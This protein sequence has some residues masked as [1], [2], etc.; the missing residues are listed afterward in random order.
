MNISNEELLSKT[1]NTRVLSNTSFNNGLLGYSSFPANNKGNVITFSDTTVGAETVF[2]QRNDFIGYSHIQTMTPVYEG[3][4]LSPGV[5]FYIISAIRKAI[6]GKY[7]Y[8]IKFNRRI[9]KEVLIRLPV[10]S[11]KRLDLEYMKK[12][13][14]EIMNVCLLRIKAEHDFKL[15]EYMR[16]LSFDS[17]EE[18]LLNEA[19]YEV[20][21]EWKSSKS[22]IYKLEDLFD[23]IDRGMRIKSSDRKQGDLPFITAGLINMGLSSYID[24]STCRIFPENSLTIDM[25]GSTFYRGYNFGADDHVTVLTNSKHRFNKECLQ[26]LQVIIEKRLVGKFSYSRNFYPKNAKD[27]TIFLPE[28]ASDVDITLMQNYIKVIGKIVI[29]KIISEFK[30]KEKILLEVITNGEI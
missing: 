21:K 19:D 13:S 9:A 8:G 25:F 27:L 4:E 17:I 20:L 15:R 11:K 26:Y 18:S 23:K 7:N 28:R 2:Y 10:T 3:L 29:G 30:E 5:A 14:K 22:A 6:A 16:I 24:K 1:G 12:Y